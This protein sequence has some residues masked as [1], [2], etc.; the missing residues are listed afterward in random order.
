MQCSMTALLSQLKQKNHYWDPS[1]CAR[2]TPIDSDQP[3][4]TPFILAKHDL[5]TKEM[6]VGSHRSSMMPGVHTVVQPLSD[7]I[8]CNSSCT[9]V[10]ANGKAFDKMS[11]LL[12]AGVHPLKNNAGHP[13]EQ[14]DLD[15]KTDWLPLGQGSLAVGDDVPGFADVAVE[16]VPSE[17]RQPSWKMQHMTNP[18]TCES[19]S[20]CN[21][22]SVV[23]EDRFSTCGPNSSFS[24]M[25]CPSDAT[26]NT[27]ATG[28]TASTYTSRDDRDFHA[29]LAALN[30]DIARLQ[31]TL[32]GMLFLPGEEL[33]TN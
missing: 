24:A 18:D 30:A 3:R 2:S 27:G 26:C 11:Y 8:D 25:L 14:G 13:V 9:L 29:G 21:A 31:S 23:Q 16:S 4:L 28:I 7:V 32:K 17:F 20:E 6:T 12:P 33:F 1:R 10:Q 19:A 5:L 15:H 22:I